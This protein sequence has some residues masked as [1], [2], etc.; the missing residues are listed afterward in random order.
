MKLTINKPTDF[1]A[2]YLK[3]DAGVRYWEDTVINGVQDTDCEETDGSPKMPCAENIGER[4]G[5]LRGNDWRWRPVI[6]I[7]N[8]VIVNWIKGTT[9][10]VHYKVCDD[11]V[12]TIT[13]KDDN[14]I[15]SYDG[16]VPN[17]M[18]PADDGFGDYIIMCIDA[19]GKIENWNKELIKELVKEEED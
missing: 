14:G 10:R 2:K 8:G 3:V 13:D 11:G 7:D 5:V 15:V 12:Y 1:E 16:Y 9:A 17:I 6:D 18:C 4:H 19:D